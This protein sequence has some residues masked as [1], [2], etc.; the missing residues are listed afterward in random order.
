MWTA[1]DQR[2]MR[3]RFKQFGAALEPPER[4]EYASFGV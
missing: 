4:G 2:L 1:G 3:L